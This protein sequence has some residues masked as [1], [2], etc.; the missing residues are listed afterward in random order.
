M[1]QCLD[2]SLSRVPRV[3]RALRAVA[4]HSPIDFGP[5]YVI[6]LPNTFLIV[7]VLLLALYLQSSEVRAL[8]FIYYC[9]FRVYNQKLS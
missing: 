3:P 6:R 4:I 9:V 2:L 8:S 1:S 7:Y 5:M